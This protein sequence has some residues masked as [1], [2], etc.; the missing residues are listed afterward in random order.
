MRDLQTWLVGDEWKEEEQLNASK[1]TSFILFFSIPTKEYAIRLLLL[2][3]TSHDCSHIFDQHA[4][5]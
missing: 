1:G 5:L 4:R 2:H 3:H